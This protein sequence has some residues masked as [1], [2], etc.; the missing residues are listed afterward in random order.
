MAEQDNEAEAGAKSPLK[1]ILI[2][3]VGV[4]FLLAGAVAGTLYF[5]G[6]FGPKDGA[7]AEEKLAQAEAKAGA[8]KDPARSSTPQLV[9]ER[10]GAPGEAASA[11]KD[12]ASAAKSSKP[13]V[14]LDA[15]PESRRFVYS[16]LEL[17][18]PLVA[19][20]TGSRKVMQAHLAMMTRYDE[21]VFKNVKRHEFALRAA[22]LD[23][24]RLTTDA[25][26]EKPDFRTALAERIRL[27]LNAKLEKFEE[28]GGIEA[29]YFTS[30]VVQ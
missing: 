16:Y 25:D 27:E 20:L 9:V 17:E 29:V 4:V 12:G 10:P 22:A 28:F 7:S 2:G 19:N 21:R 30:F 24:M 5:A 3:S 14:V 1:W 6:F 18:R 11:A 23:V 13:Q 8:A 15:S 26:I